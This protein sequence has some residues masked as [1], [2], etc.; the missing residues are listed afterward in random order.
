L[1]KGLRH[2][3][4]SEQVLIDKNRVSFSTILA[5]IN[6]QSGI[7]KFRFEIDY[8]LEYKSFFVSAIR[9]RLRFPGRKGIFLSGGMDSTAVL[10]FMGGE[11]GLNTEN[12]FAYTSMPDS[13]YLRISFNEESSIY[14]L[15]LHKLTNMV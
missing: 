15:L 8:F 13:K 12:F 4:N 1:Y 3:K 2:I 9:S 5:K 10:Y 11:A 6:L 7:V 14:T